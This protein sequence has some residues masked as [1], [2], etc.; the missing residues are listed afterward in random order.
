MW[1]ASRSAHESIA[2][3]QGSSFPM[4][5]LWHRPDLSE[6]VV[7]RLEDWAGGSRK[8]LGLGRQAFAELIGGLPR[9]EGDR[10][11]PPSA[12]RR[13]RASFQGPERSDRADPRQNSASRSSPSSGTRKVSVASAGEGSPGRDRPG[14]FTSPSRRV[15][16]RP[17]SPSR[18]ASGTSPSDGFQKSHKGTRLRGSPRVSPRIRLRR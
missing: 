7:C 3:G 4:F 18:S 17:R 14:P 8:A 11:A 1:E 9:W 13:E 16:S 5:F 10:V 12:S 6:S 15:A 2:A